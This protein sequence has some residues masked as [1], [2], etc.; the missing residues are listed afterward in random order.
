MCLFSLR[1]EWEKSKN[2]TKLK[3]LL[4]LNSSTYLAYIY[5]ILFFVWSYVRSSRSVLDYIVKLF[6]TEMQSK[7]NYYDC[8][9]S[10]ATN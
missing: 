9:S 10:T 4:L 1:A 3:L 5:Y 8:L 6:A 7:T 2:K